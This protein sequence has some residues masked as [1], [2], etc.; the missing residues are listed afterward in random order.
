VS[1]YNSEIYVSGTHGLYV[2]ALIVSSLYTSL[3]PIATQ[4]TV[5]KEKHFSFVS[6]STVKYYVVL[7]YYT[8]LIDL[9]PSNYNLPQQKI[10]LV[11]VATGSIKINHR[12]HVNFGIV[13]R[14]IMQKIIIC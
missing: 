2:P 5:G 6:V 7:F 4:N 1:S 8:F 11:V 14:I 10:G 9:P 13:Q 3:L 12:T